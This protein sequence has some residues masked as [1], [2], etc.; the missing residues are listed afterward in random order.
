M[1]DPR[2]QLRF[3]VPPG[4]EAALQRRRGPGRA[5]PS[6]VPLPVAAPGPGKALPSGSRLAAFGQL[7]GGL[8]H[9]CQGPGPFDQPGLEL[10]GSFGAEPVD[11][12]VIAPPRPD[13][14][15]MY[16]NTGYG[17]RPARVDAKT[18]ASRERRMECRV[19]AEVKG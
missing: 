12:L 18:A 3:P 15:L 7:G 14:P 1:P 9:Q 16:V 6:H 5:W 19:R 10:G 17:P 13:G 11:C 4:G 2:A 8:G